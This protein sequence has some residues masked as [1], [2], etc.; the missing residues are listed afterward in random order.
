MSEFRR[1]QPSYELI[2]NYG[3]TQYVRDTTKQEAIANAELDRLTR[4][5]M[6]KLMAER[7][8][9]VNT[10]PATTLAPA[11]PA[12]QPEPAGVDEADIMAQAI[13]EGALG[14]ANVLVPTGDETLGD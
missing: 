10:R 4:I 7:R 6:A 8:L 13:T 12:T 14:T 11:T 1:P 9:G 2:E 3:K 5:E